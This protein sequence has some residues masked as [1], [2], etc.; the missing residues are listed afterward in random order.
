MDR[1]L[2]GF[3]GHFVPAVLATERTLQKE[4]HSYNLEASSSFSIVVPGDRCKHEL[5]TSQG[6]LLSLH[7]A[8]ALRR[9]GERVERMGNRPE[10]PCRGLWGH[11]HHRPTVKMSMCT[12]YS[13]R[14]L[15]FCF[16][17]RFSMLETFWVSQSILLFYLYDFFKTRLY[18]TFGL[19]TK[20]ENTHGLTGNF[21]ETH[22]L[23]DALP[24]T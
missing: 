3:R 18:V 23:K 2:L 13:I 11:G 20:C 1:P 22:T 24:A 9:A 16:G 17:A 7:G 12:A 4:H 15:L 6:P 10:A 21:L 19:L 14:N 8:C 5:V